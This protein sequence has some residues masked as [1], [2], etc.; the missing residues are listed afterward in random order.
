MFTFVTFNALSA[1]L[2]DCSAS[3]FCTCTVSTKRLVTGTQGVLTV[4]VT[5]VGD[6][7][8]F[9]AVTYIVEILV[10]VTVATD[11]VHQ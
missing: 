11:V 4:S 1:I 8:W 7:V 3:L 6:G 2:I 9:A 5:I 10:W